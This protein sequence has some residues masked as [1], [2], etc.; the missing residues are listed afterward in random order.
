LPANA[1]LAQARALQQEA[2]AALA[3]CGPEGLRVDASGLA[4]FDTATIALLLHVQR[5]A[6]A[7]GVPLRVRGLPP[8]LRDLAQLYGVDGLLSLDPEPE[9]GSRPAVT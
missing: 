9:A 4:A 8:R 5:S 7:R 3:R 6:R 1:A 2:D